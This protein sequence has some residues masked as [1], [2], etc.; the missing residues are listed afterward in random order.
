MKARTISQQRKEEK[1]LHA[2]FGDR[3]YAVNKNGEIT[4]DQ[5]ISYDNVIIETQ[6]IR[7]AF[8]SD[9]TVGNVLVVGKNKGVYLRSW[10]ALKVKY[11]DDD[12]KDVL[13]YLLNVSKD[14][15]RPYYFADY[16]IVDIGKDGGFAGIAD[17][18]RRSVSF[19]SIRQQAQSQNIQKRK[20]RIVA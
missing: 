7:R 5:L 6:D 14:S 9:D 18:F 12:G 17:D 13:T 4:C 8:F 15:L 19:D 2:F 3:G 16:N 11:K 20:Y 1:M 10:Q